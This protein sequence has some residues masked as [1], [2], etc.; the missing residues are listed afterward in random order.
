MMGYGGKR[1]RSRV[2]VV[3]EILNEALDGANKTRLMYRCN[4]NFRRFNRYL[5]ELLDA[6]LLERIAPNPESGL[7]LYRTTEKGRELLKILQKAGEFL[8]V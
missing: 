4:L 8:S 6:G 3:V 1:R 5:K 2:E 7:V